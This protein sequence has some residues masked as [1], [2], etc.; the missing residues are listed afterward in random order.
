MDETCKGRHTVTAK[1]DSETRESLDRDA[2]RLGD[3]RADR[4]RDALKIYL[5]MRRG[6][7]QCPECGNTIQLKP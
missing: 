4:I 2:D 3:F 1:V 5:A 6:K 7:W